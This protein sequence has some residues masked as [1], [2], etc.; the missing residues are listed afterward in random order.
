MQ[1]IDLQVQHRDGSPSE[2]VDV[3]SGL[4][5]VHDV[6]SG[7]GI[8]LVLVGGMGTVDRKNSIVRMKAC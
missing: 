8:F 7:R 6:E 3:Q 1:N 4:S 5:C 2:R